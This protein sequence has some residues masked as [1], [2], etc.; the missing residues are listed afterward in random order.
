MAPIDFYYMPG[1]PPC[2][3]VEMVANMV[4]VKL[5]KHHINLFKGEHLKED[6]VKLNPLHKVPF[7]VD[8]DFKMSESRAIMTYLVNK[9]KP[10]DEFLYPKDPTER[11]R[12]DELLHYDIGTLYPAS[13][14]LYRPVLLGQTK[15]FDPEL[16]KAFK[17]TVQY[18]DERLASNG[19]KKFMLGDN[20]TVADINLSASLSMPICF[21]IDLSEFKNLTNYLERMKV[22]IPKYNEIN[23]EQLEDLKKF[24]ASRLEGN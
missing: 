24:I 10:D 4:G 15:E 19:G 13:S 14:N 16:V 9:Y 12:V 6:F 22:A 3:A 1:S 5:N 2:R 11:A 17:L 20:L 8:G 23:D 21:G 7:I 18:L